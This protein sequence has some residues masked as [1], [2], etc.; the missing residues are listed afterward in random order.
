MAQHIYAV[1]AGDTLKNVSRRFFALGN[2]TEDIVKSNDFLGYRR[3]SGNTDL[4]GTP[5]IFAG[6]VLRIVT[7]DAGISAVQ[8]KQPDEVTLY[9]N[10]EKVDIPDGSL[11]SLGYDRCCD[12][13]SG[14][15]PWDP[16]SQRDRVF[17]QPDNPPTVKVFC[18][19]NQVFGGKFEVTQP[20]SPIKERRVHAEARSHT[21]KIQ[22]SNIPANKYPLEREGENLLQLAEWVSGIWGQRIEDLTGATEPFKKTSLGNGTKA[23]NWLM[24]LA[25]T[26]AR[27]MSPTADG[28]GLIIKSPENLAPSVATFTEGIN[29]FE[30]PQP[31]YNTADL[32]GTYLA[33]IDAGNNPGKLIVYRDPD[34]SED[35]VAFENLTDADD[36]TAQAALEYAARKKYRNFFEM[37]M[38]ASPGIL[39]PLGNMWAPGQVITLNAPS[40]M[41]YNNFDFMVRTV[42]LNLGKSAVTPVLGI[43]PPEVYRG[44]RVKRFPWAV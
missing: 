31:S 43:I 14:D 28:F 37:S 18:G 10:E 33:T 24:N 44:E 27:V 35:S 22:K 39:N 26:R 6:D 7:D 42:D 16:N 21:L 30:P 12:S 3:E 32:H 23:F 5:N 38:I 13:F 1:K 40:A 19:S 25:T 41:I 4:G 9:L 34:F 11:L 2:K 36:S 17:W 8:G 20:R 15:F 29:G